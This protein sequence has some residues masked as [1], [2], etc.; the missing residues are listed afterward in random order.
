[1]CL[2]VTYYESISGKELMPCCRLS[3]G[4]VKTSL[5]GMKPYRGLIH[6]KIPITSIGS[7]VLGNVAALPFENSSFDLATAFETVYFWPDVEMAFRQ[8][9]RVLR[10]G[11]IFMICNESDGIDAGGKKWE[12]KIDGMKVYTAEELRAYL[13][14]AGFDQIEAIHHP[15][16]PWLCVVAQKH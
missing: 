8:V 6:K 14:H 1:M 3:V 9:V 2:S 16:K 10:P 4:C 5:G 15:Q 13:L 11:G 7:V 12:K